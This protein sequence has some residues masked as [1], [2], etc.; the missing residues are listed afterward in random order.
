MVSTG[1]AVSS[2]GRLF[3]NYPLGLDRTDTSY[4]VAELTGNTTEVPYP[5]VALN[6]PPGGAINYTTTPPVCL[7]SSLTSKEDVLIL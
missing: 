6:T 3:S 7:V 4:Q 1:I 2:T 5:S